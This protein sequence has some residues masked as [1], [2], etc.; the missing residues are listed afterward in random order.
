MAKPLPNIMDRLKKKTAPAKSTGPAA[1]KTESAPGTPVPGIRQQQV[2][3]SAGKGPGHSPELENFQTRLGQ[4]YGLSSADVDG[5]YGYK[6]HNAFVQLKKNLAGLPTLTFPETLLNKGLSHAEFDTPVKKA[7]DVPPEARTLAL[8][9]IRMYQSGT[10]GPSK[11]TPESRQVFEI[12]LP[13]G[14]GKFPIADFI[15]LLPDA[16][17]L[18][19]GLTTETGSWRNDGDMTPQNRRMILSSLITIFTYLQYHGLMTESDPYN[20]SEKGLAEFKSAMIKVRAGLENINEERGAEILTKQQIE[21][22]STFGEYVMR[23]YFALRAYRESGRETQAVGERHIVDFFN[24]SGPYNKNKEFGNS[25]LTRLWNEIGNDADKRTKFVIWLRNDSQLGKLSRQV[26]TDSGQAFGD[27]GAIARLTGEITKR[28][29][30][31]PE[32]ILGALKSAAIKHQMTKEAAGLF[33]TVLTKLFDEKD[34]S[35]VDPELASTITQI[36]DAMGVEVGDLGQMFDKVTG[37]EVVEEHLKTA[38]LDS[39][40]KQADIGDAEDDESDEAAP[41]G[42]PKTTPKPVGPDPYKPSAEHRSEMF[43]AKKN[44]IEQD[45]KLVGLPRIIRDM[46]LAWSLDRI[47]LTAVD[48]FI[49]VQQLAR[50][51]L[52]SFVKLALLAGIVGGIGYAG[53]KVYDH[54]KHPSSAEMA[55]GKTEGLAPSPSAKTA[56]MKEHKATNILEREIDRAFE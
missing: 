4:N 1:G 14:E 29:A 33:S 39:L 2:G 47:N 37:K 21:T 27:A 46:K 16:R 34:G 15:M 41:R 7:E 5:F 36:A 44:L 51:L 19:T 40:M 32:A 9:A 42:K 28:M 11:L 52:G 10:D 30:N 6:T 23:L 20:M 17:Q 54:F 24:A 26:I 31:E 12:N 48:K 45:W 8:K 35:V 53:K 49:I 18:A 13:E 55:S 22:F 56:P 3:P 50:R 43:R 25:Y 38:T